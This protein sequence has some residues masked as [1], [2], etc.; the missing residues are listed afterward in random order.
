MLVG[1]RQLEKKLLLLCNS[2]IKTNKT[3]LTFIDH[4]LYVRDCAKHL[5]GIVSSISFQK[6]MRSV[7]NHAQ[8]KMKELRLKMNPICLTI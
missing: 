5:T 7:V 8:F 6:M 4:S 3:E 1:F 2:P